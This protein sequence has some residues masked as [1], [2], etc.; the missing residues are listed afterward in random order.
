LGGSILAPMR[1][2][3]LSVGEVTVYVKRLMDRDEVL[4][5]LIV[6][7]EISNFRRPASGHMYF[8]LKDDRSL[9]HAVCFRGHAAKLGFDPE[10]GMQVVAGGNITV[11]ERQGRYQLITRF[12]RPDGVGALAAAFEKLKAKLEAEGL[13]AEDRKRPLPRFPRAIALVTSGTGAAVRDMVS[14]LGSRYPLARIKLIP[15]LVQG[16]GSAQSIVNSLRT[17]NGAEVDLI[18]LGRGGGS[19]E[20]LWSFNEEAVAREV[21]ASRVPVISAVGHETDYA[22]T[23]FAADARAATPSH[24]A[25]MAVPDAEELLSSLAGLRYRASSRLRMLLRESGL[26]LQAARAHPLL[27]RPR[28]LVDNKA[29]QLDDLR[30]SLIANAR[31]LSRLWQARLD[32]IAARLAGLDPQAV[33]RRG[34]SIVRRAD[35]DSL[36]TSIGAVA[37]GDQLAIAVTDGEIAAE[38]RGATAGG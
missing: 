16:E 30:K 2:S 6:R 33:L 14:I 11:Y 1:T 32:T 28:L 36:V 9:L 38:V 21:F 10:D 19:L 23:D 5:D 31:R 18:I 37:A 3:I 25:E 35:D 24:A 15:T 29:Q 8:S 27:E 26:R 17:A 13:F 20:D 34:Y 12:M 22:L 7:G 4:A